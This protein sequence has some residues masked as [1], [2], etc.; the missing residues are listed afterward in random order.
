MDKVNASFRNGVLEIPFPKTEE[1]KKS[2]VNVK[3]A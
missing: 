2:V 1:A 3:V